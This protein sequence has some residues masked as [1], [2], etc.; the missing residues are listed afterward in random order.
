MA[1]TLLPKA[2]ELI[3]SAKNACPHLSEH[4]DMC[5]VMEL[6][7]RGIITFDK[8]YNEARAALGRPPREDIGDPNQAEGDKLDRQERTTVARLALRYIA[9]HLTREEIERIIDVT[10]KRDALKEVDELARQSTLPTRVLAERVARFAQLPL[11]EYPLPPEEVLGTR[12]ALIRSLI[13]DQ[14]EF[15]GIAKNYLR[16]RDIAKVASKL[17]DVAGGQGRIGGKAG[18]MVL[19]SKILTTFKDLHPEWPVHTPESWFLRS[20]VLGVFLELNHLTGYQSQKYKPIDQ[21]RHEYPLIKGVL[22]NSDFPVEVVQQLRA[23]LRE[24]GTHPLIVRSSSLLEDRIGTAFSG[25]YASVF[26]ANQ[27]ELE[28]RLQALLVAISEVYA[29]TLAPDPVAYRRAHNLLDYH[30][31]MGVLIQKVVGTQVGRYFLP[32]FAGV[33]FSRN[34]YRWSPR[35]RREDGMMRLVMGLGTRAVDRVASDYPRMVAL[36]LPTLRP[37]TTAKEMMRYS[38]R[39]IDAINLEANRL[40]SVP[41]EEILAAGEFPML[42]RI[43]AIARDDGLYPPM[44]TAVRAEPEDVFVT[45]DKLLANTSFAEAM[46]RMLVRLE[47]AYGSPVD[48]EFACDGQKFFLLQCRALA[49]GADVAAVHVPDDVPVRDRLFS[50]SCYV[51]S[52]LVAD[53]E[54]VVYVNSHVYDRVETLEQRYEIGRIVGRLNQAL[55]DKR[56]ILVGPGR[57]GSNDI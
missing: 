20:D 43:V 42:D 13:S 41:L 38:Q 28:T 8:L 47:E 54:Y 14:L 25:K 36:G 21:V 10:I 3:A 45:F 27:G 1:G 40:E 55:A 30:E 18:G 19:A 34:E 44:G 23:V 32:A 39:T 49:S 5:F 24:I 6:H 51:R 37:E 48:V 56:F 50:A 52:G 12:V 16:V 57:W 35:I 15:I 11:K 53:I 26:V 22:R 7:N 29:S 46:R 33:A 17:I 9:R 4:I 2:Q 31:D